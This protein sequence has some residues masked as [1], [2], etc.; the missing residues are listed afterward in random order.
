V[1]VAILVSSA[2]QT[3]K[4]VQVELTLEAPHLGEL[5]VDRKQFLELFGLADDKAATVLLPAKDILMAVRCHF[6][7][8]LVE[9]NGKRSSHS[10]SSWTVV[11]GIR[12]VGV[13]MVVMLHNDVRV[14]RLVLSAAG[15]AAAGSL[16]DRC[17]HS[18]WEF[19]AAYALTAA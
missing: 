4:A 1:V 16:L 7:K 17:V 13:V 19:E 14:L 8:H 11:N 9:A 3:L 15:A 5:E 18:G 10:T 6:V 12:F 2:S